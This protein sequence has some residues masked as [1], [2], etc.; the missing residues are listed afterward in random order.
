MSIFFLVVALMVAVILLSRLTWWS[1]WGER[2]SVEHH[3]QAM[4]RALMQL[5]HLG[6]LYQSEIWTLMRENFEQCQSSVDNLDLI[7]RSGILLCLTM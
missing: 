7:R 4:R 2:R 6:D 5:E 3:E 1:R